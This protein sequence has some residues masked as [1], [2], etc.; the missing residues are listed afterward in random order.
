MRI[1]LTFLGVSLLAG[2][3]GMAPQAIRTFDAG[4]Y[5]EAQKGLEKLAADGDPVAMADLGYIY[6][7]GLGFMLHGRD[8]E[9]ARD[10]YQKS[11]NAGVTVAKTRLAVLDLEASHTP[12]DIPQAV[13]LL[14]QADAE[15]D[16]LATYDLSLLYEQGIGV[17]QD[18]AETQRLRAKIG[19]ALD[20]EF[21]YIH[22]VISDDMQAHLEYQHVDHHG[23]TTTIQFGRHDVFADWVKVYRSSGY[24]DLDQ[25]ALRAVKHSPFPP[26]PPGVLTPPTGFVDVY[27]Q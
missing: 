11:I 6:E 2:C 12:R 24:D 19:H 8:E 27:F 13:V 5:Q 14:K 16:L 22:R 23:V 25:L 26:M 18:E 17:P 4:K 15:G 7:Y 3:A 20:D 10:W 1:A 9:G 21:A